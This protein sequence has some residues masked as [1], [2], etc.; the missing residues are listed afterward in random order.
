MSQFTQCKRD[1]NLSKTNDT[2]AKWFSLA[3]L[4]EQVEK[5][6][7]AETAQTIYLDELKFTI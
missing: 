5:Q 6:I 2:E 3:I 7:D 4:E 1:T